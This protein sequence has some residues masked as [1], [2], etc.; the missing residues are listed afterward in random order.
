MT[1]EKKE[2]ERREEHEPRE[3]HRR[4]AHTDP[5]KL[6]AE[7]SEEHQRAA[8]GEVV[9]EHLT[10]AAKAALDREDDFRKEAERLQKSDD[11]E[12][13]AVQRQQV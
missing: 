2:T 11:P 3:E 1:E 9:R 13:V 8:E 4:R 6:G 5:K 12:D 7:L 10:D